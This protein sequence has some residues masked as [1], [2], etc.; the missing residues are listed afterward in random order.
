MTGGTLSLLLGNLLIAVIM[1]LN[2]F[3]LIVAASLRSS[4][5][6]LWLVSGR[7]GAVVGEGLRRTLLILG[8]VGSL[9]PSGMG[10]MAGIGGSVKG[11][12]IEISFPWDDNK[13]ARPCAR[14]SS[15]MLTR[16]GRAGRG[17]MGCVTSS[18]S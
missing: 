10:H 12:S 14:C 11:C 8:S 7:L 15:F 17:R 4:P 18:G 13:A 3:R 9:S 2:C 1:P 16:R 5:V 6:S